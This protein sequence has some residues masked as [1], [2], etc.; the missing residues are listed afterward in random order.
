MERI[1]P[2]FRRTQKAFDSIDYDPLIMIPSRRLVL[3]LA[4]HHMLTSHPQD[5]LGLPLVGIGERTL[6]GMRLAMVDVRCLAMVSDRQRFA[7][8]GLMTP[9]KIT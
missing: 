4:D 7:P 9:N 1:L 2:L 6:R 8:V 3:L 5:G